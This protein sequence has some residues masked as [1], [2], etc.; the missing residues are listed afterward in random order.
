M[1]G[2]DTVSLNASI[3]SP[4]G[5]TLA[6]SFKSIKI[7]DN[8]VATLTLSGPVSLSEGD[9]GTKP[10]TFNLILNKATEGGFTID[11]TSVDGTAKVADN[12]YIPVNSFLTFNGTVNESYP[13]TVLVNGDK[14]I[15]ADETFTIKLDNLSNS[16]EG[17]V[18]IPVLNATGTITNED[19]ET[20]TITKAN[21]AEGITGVSYTFIFLSGYTSDQPIINNQ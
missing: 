8:D 10:A 9:S 20:L 3:V 1:E 15:E 7:L 16:F 17:R 4:A 13:I 6:N 21:G 12:D 5:V 2:T 18:T 19:S 14:N 11:Y